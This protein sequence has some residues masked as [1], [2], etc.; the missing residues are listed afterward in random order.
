M[1]PSH[2]DDVVLLRMTL[3]KVNVIIWEPRNAHI[4]LLV[5][6]T[7]I[8]VTDSN[9]ADGS[10]LTMHMIV[11]DLGWHRQVIITWT[12]CQANGNDVE[13]SLHQFILSLYYT[14]EIWTNHFTP[15]VTV[16]D[17]FYDMHLNIAHLNTLDAALVYLISYLL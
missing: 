5:A 13:V 4:L 7:Y 2:Q 9:T 16:G 8:R 10:Y 11:L 14:T 15:G 1:V 17:T 12:H 6:P 3:N